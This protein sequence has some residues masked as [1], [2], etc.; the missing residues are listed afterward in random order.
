[1]LESPFS[2][3]SRNRRT[4]H[5]RPT[6]GFWRKPDSSEVAPSGSAVSQGR[7]ADAPHHLQPAPGLQPEPSG[8]TWHLGLGLDAVP[9]ST[10][11]PVAEH[12]HCRLTAKVFHLLGAGDMSSVSTIDLAVVVQYDLSFLR[13]SRATTARGFLRSQKLSLADAPIETTNNWVQVG[14]TI[15][16]T[17]SSRGRRTPEEGLVIA[18][19]LDS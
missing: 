19:P 8:P 13:E 11:R 7:A 10:E 1:M 12:A 3:N 15:S 16:H 14:R 9:N 18:V 5:P 4:A 17:T 2:T 6:K